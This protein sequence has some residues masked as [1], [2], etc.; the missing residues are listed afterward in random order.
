[1]SSTSLP[2]Q[3]ISSLGFGHRWGLEMANNFLVLVALAARR[4][5]AKAA[6]AT[7]FLARCRNRSSGGIDHYH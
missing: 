7:I 3:Y 6:H 1:M 2:N 4:F 5:A